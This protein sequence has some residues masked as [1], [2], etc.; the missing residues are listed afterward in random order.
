MTQLNGMITIV[1]GGAHGLGEATAR[2]FVA[3]G[4]TVLL[5]DIQ[6]ERGA[7]VAKEIGA[8]FFAADVTIENEVA[9]LVA[10]GIKR[11]GRLDCM[12]N[13][14]GLLGPVTSIGEIS[15]I[16]WGDTIAVLLSSVFYGMKHAARAMIA[17]RS[18]VI[19]STASVAGI[20]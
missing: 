12:I 13:N 11:Y 10:E 20:V 16:E 6:A 3:D 1:T 5:S 9:A 15:G 19:L 17:Q 4:A 18:G 14:A 7:A 2:R 8:V